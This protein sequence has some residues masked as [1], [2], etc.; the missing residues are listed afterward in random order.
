MYSNVVQRQNITEKTFFS[1]IDGCECW[2]LSF[3]TCES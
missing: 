1:C 3:I 2:M